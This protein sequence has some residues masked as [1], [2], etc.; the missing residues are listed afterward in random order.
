M[1]LTH[2]T[3]RPVLLDAF[4]REGIAS[5]TLAELQATQAIGWLECRYGSARATNNWGC[6]QCKNPIAC[7]VACEQCTPPPRDGCAPLTDHYA[8]GPP[9]FGAAYCGYY[10]T[11]PTPVDGAASLVHELYRRP[12]VAPLMPTGD[13][14]AIANAMKYGEPH[15]FDAEPG[16]YAKT[17][18]AVASDIAKALGEPWVVRRGGGA[19][20]GPRAGIAL[21]FGAALGAAAAALHR[22]L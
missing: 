9:K 11:Y 17:M 3:A 16:G 20:G 6:V 2:V 14:T 7:D 22:W 8:K 18:E 21:G 10:R 5:P 4:K 19:L 1:K 15:Y 12:A 13:A